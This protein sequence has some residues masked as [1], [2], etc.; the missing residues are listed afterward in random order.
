MHD[1][2]R[3]ESRLTLSRVLA[4]CWWN[5]LG[6][7]NEDKFEEI[8]AQ[9][10]APGVKS[11][12]AIRVPG[13]TAR[14]GDSGVRRHGVGAARRSVPSGPRRGSARLRVQRCSVRP[15][16]GPLGVRPVRPGWASSQDFSPWPKEKKMK[17]L[18][19]FQ[20]FSNSK[21]IWIHIKFEFRWL[22]LTQ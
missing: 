10:L 13:H 6:F 16:D 7:R 17:M 22:L 14:G 15:T 8:S 20:I 2:G 5:L 1:L 4:S 11:G 9:M 3:L 19:N 12:L 18:F 21:P